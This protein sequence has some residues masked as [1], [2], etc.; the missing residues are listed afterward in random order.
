M[1]YLLI[2]NSI[3]LHF[4]PGILR[5]WITF[6]EMQ[7][8]ATGGASRLVSPILLGWSVL[9]FV[10]APSILTAIYRGA[11]IETWN[12]QLRSAVQARERHSE[13]GTKGGS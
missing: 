11:T 13:S 2:V 8:M 5:I 7:G 6:N 4:P 9:I 3:S 1:D 12:P 10:N